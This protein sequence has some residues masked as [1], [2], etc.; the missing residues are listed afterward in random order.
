MDVLVQS[1]APD[2]LRC[3]LV[4]GITLPLRCDCLQRSRQRVKT[5]EHEIQRERQKTFDDS[6]TFQPA[7]N[8]RSNKMAVQIR[9]GGPAF[10]TSARSAIRRRQNYDELM[11][12]CTFTPKV[13]PVK[14]KM[15]TA[16]EY[17]EQNA[18]DRLFHGPAG[19]ASPTEA[20]CATVFVFTCVYTGVFLS[21]F[22][23]R[24]ASVGVSWDCIVVCG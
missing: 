13:N 17:L 1:V 2:L 22:L 7:I 9:T 23:S 10:N 20:M 6:C 14:T 21:L 3:S 12:E 16:A 4:R 11:A 24:V 18:F 15:T 5:T 8:P 19:P